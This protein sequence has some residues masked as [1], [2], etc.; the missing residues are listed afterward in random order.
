[1]PVLWQ[2]IKESLIKGIKELLN[3]IP[4]K[5]IREIRQAKP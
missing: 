2:E 1:M 4:E 3:R 5:E